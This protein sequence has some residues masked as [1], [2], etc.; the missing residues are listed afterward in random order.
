ML[1]SNV[2]R[3]FWG[4]SCFG[5]RKAMMECEVGARNALFETMEKGVLGVNSDPMD[6]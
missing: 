4:R 3:R 1:A 5:P 6:P 2:H